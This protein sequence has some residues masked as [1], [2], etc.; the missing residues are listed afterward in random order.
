MD[1]HL[2][3][4]YEYIYGNNDNSFLGEPVLGKLLN[5]IKLSNLIT[6]Y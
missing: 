3:A 4:Q 5:L 1:F 6:K 2:Y